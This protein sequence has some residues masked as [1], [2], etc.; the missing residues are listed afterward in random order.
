MC[1]CIYS[2]KVRTFPEA[3]M[4]RK[5]TSDPRVEG[6]RVM[7]SMSHIKSDLGD[8]H[9]TSLQRHVCHKTGGSW[10]HKPRK[11]QRA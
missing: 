11:V 7:A 2:K 1:A 8:S 9:L 10:S 4:R 5:H 6:R 3:N